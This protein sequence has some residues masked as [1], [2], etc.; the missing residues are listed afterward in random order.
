MTLAAGSDSISAM[1]QAMFVLLLSVLLP[2]SGLAEEDYF[3][4]ECAPTLDRLL[5]RNRVPRTEL[6]VMSHEAVVSKATRSALQKRGYYS[7]QNTRHLRCHLGRDTLELHINYWPSREGYGP[8]YAAEYWQALFYWNSHELD[9]FY[10]MAGDFCQPGNDLLHSI[11]FLSTL[12]TLTV[13][14]CIRMEI[15]EEQDPP[16]CT[17]R[18]VERPTKRP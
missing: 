18:T 10:L 5:V 2:A 16:T 14:A 12:T 7:V 3:Q 11:Q 9:P 4:F 15:S 13:E 17:T 8:C 1:N 6:G